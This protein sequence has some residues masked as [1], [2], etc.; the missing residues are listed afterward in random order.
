MSLNYRHLFVLYAEQMQL[1]PRRKITLQRTL[2][3]PDLVSCQHR[4]RR[5]IARKMSNIGVTTILYFNCFKPTTLTFRFHTFV[6]PL[7]NFNIFLS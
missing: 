1:V 2:Y 7:M 5:P 4:I 6:T 3:L